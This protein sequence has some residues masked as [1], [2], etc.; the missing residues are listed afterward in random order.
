MKLI[1]NADDFGLDENRTRA[2]C[3]AFKRGLVTTTTV[4]SNMPWFEQ[5]MKL[6]T[7]EGWL[8]KV[9]LHFNLTEGVPLTEQMRD[10]RELC[11]A[12]GEFNAIF[13]QTLTGRLWLSRGASAAIGAEAHAQIQKYL[14]RGGRMMHLDSHHHVHTDFSVG[15]ILLPIAKRYGFKTCRMSRNVP[16]QM[17]FS[18][19]VYKYLYNRWARSIIPFNADYFTDFSGFE[20]TYAKLPPNAAVE[21]MTH[22]LYRNRDGDIADEGIFMDYRRPIEDEITFLVELKRV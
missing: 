11:N 6:A 15:R 3:E 16:R 10:C 14:D 2:I 5:A 18:K 12:Q 8:D 1:V 21:I 22:P 20:E 17:S 9:G 4:M 13:H 7:A 19:K